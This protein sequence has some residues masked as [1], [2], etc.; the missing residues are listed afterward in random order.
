MLEFTKLVL[1]D[2]HKI[3]PFFSYS[4]NMICDNTVGGA[5]MWRDYFEV[6]YAIFDDTVIFKAKVKYHNNVTAFSPPL[7]KNV[8]GGFD[9][10][11]QYCNAQELPL[12][13][14][15][16]T[17][18]DLEILHELFGDY[19]SLYYEDW[20]DYL[21]N[22]DDL[23]SLKGRKFSGQRNH[24]NFFK[25]NFEDYSF[26]VITENNIN[27]IFEFYREL[28]LK[29][30]KGG[31]VFTEEYNKTI[32]V[33]ENFDAYEALGGLIRVNGKVIAFSLGEIVNG[34]LFVHVEKA[35]ITYRG[36]YQIINNEFAKH[37]CS[38]DVLFINRE[39]DV[40]DEGLRAAKKAYHP[41]RIID[42][43]IVIPVESQ[44]NVWPNG[45]GGRFSIKNFYT[46]QPFGVLRGI[47]NRR[48]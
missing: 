12:V 11:M 14:Y 8:K 26:E 39:E 20:S 3:K 30:Q 18:Y 13:F 2:I 5:F 48:T 41:C 42:K 25:K 24:I 23:T 40:G 43:Y 33:L 15:N 21:Y 4:K 31:C 35:D 47:T 9:K 19:K 32:E 37:Y 1:G 10:I 7:G 27:E 28:S 44:W 34:V 38:D 29:L 6:E 46:M 22:A 36:A 16:V 45:T 17:S